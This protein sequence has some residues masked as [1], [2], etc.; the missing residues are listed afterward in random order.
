MN[1]LTKFIKCAALFASGMLA[2]T[3]AIGDINVMAS[4][5]YVNRKV[6]PKRDKDDYK[7]YRKVK[8]CWTWTNWT[9]PDA[10]AS[11]P[12]DFLAAVN[13]PTAEPVYFTNGTWLGANQFWPN[14]KR[15]YMNELGPYGTGTE[16]NLNWSFTAYAEDGT[17]ELFRFGA[18]SVRTNATDETLICW[19]SVNPYVRFV[20]TDQIN[21]TL[22]TIVGGLSNA[23]FNSENVSIGL[24]SSST[25]SSSSGLGTSTAVGRKAEASANYST[26]IGYA[27]K[28]KQ[29]YSTALGQNAKADKPDGGSDDD[30]AKSTALGYATTALGLECSAVGAQS[31]VKSA[32]G[33][34]TNS[35]AA[36]ALASVKSSYS[37]AMGESVSIGEKASKSVVIGSKSSVAEGCGMSIAIGE[38]VRVTGN[39][40]VAIGRNIDAKG[41]ENVV[42]GPA[43]KANIEAS[44]G[45][46]VSIGPSSVA[47]STAVSIGRRAGYAGSGVNSV[48]IGNAASGA[49]AN[50]VA[51]GT[52][53]AASAVNS[54]QLG[55]GINDTN[56]SLKFRNT[57]VV[58]GSGKIPAG[59][60]GGLPDTYTKSE[61]DGRFVP[62]GKFNVSSDWMP[63]WNSQP[64]F[65]HDLGDVWAINPD[66]MHYS[67]RGI[68]STP[69]TLSGYG[70]TDAKI[71]SGTIY[72]GSQSITPIVNGGSGSMSTLSVTGDFL[73]SFAPIYKRNPLDGS[74]SEIVYGISTNGTDYAHANVNLKPWGDSL[75]SSSNPAFSNA[76]LAVGIDTNAVAQIGELKEFFD[77]LPVGTVGTSLGGIILALLGAAALLKKKTSLLKSDGTAED[78]FA[79]DL[80]GKQVAVS[81]VNKL[82]DEK[83]GDVNAVLSA[84]LDGTEVA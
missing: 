76:V 66:R 2:V 55:E 32:Y 34:V 73:E 62:N 77:G 40:S 64:L 67:W 49:G 82:I 18:T 60:I 54:I 9:S 75:I 79:T 3:D 48:S 45:R 23:V 13:A 33:P 57:V 30:Y 50:A 36:G 15:K 4:R 44:A 71:E 35:F 84:A 72:L 21:G 20:T 38:G 61:A 80:L 43:A 19:D 24:E 39:E 8:D 53:A 1:R 83:V 74:S 11:A 81:A 37:V 6:G 28:A 25:G 27:A 47:N 52:S 65:Y 56:N 68:Q 69:T 16:L 7:I 29:S 31:V 14:G 42:I 22:K 70:I 10:T 5:E 46:S 41:S 51:I 12:D 58:D 59:S 17:T 63:F 78:Q 26:A